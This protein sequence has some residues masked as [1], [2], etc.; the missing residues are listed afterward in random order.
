[1]TQLDVL[2]DESEPVSKRTRRA[3]VVASI[4]DPNLKDRT[5][6]APLF[7]SMKEKQEK[8]YRKEVE[9]L[10]QS[11]KTRLS[12]W[13]N[14][15]GIEKD[16]TRVCPV[17]H[18]AS[19]SSTSTNPL[20]PEKTISPTVALGGSLPHFD[21][22][23]TPDPYAS[24][25]PSIPYSLAH[26]PARVTPPSPSIW[27][28]ILDTDP[29]LIVELTDTPVKPCI[30][31]PQFRSIDRPMQEAC[32]SV[33]SSLVRPAPGLVT[34]WTPT[35]S[36]DWRSTR[37]EPRKPHDLT[38]F[39]SKWKDEDTA[40]RRN[41][42]APV[43][44]VTGSTG[45][46]KTSLVYAAAAEL[47]IQVLE[48]S[49]AD[50]SWESNGR[51]QLSEAVKEALQSRQVKQ[52]S[53]QSQIVLIDDVDVLIR[54][55]RSVIASLVGITDD[56]KRPLV[57]TCSDASCFDGSNLFLD[58][59]F[60]IP[61]M[62][63]DRVAFLAYAYDRALDWP[64]RDE[65]TY[66]A[67]ARDCSGD[68]RKLANLVEI[69]RVHRSHNHADDYFT[70]PSQI[71][72]YLENVEGLP[73]CLVNRD[74][75]KGVID[76][77]DVAQAEME[78]LNL[79]QVSRN[80]SDL[81]VADIIADDGVSARIAL[82]R[83]CTAAKGVS[84]P[85]KALQLHSHQSSITH[86]RLHAVM[87]PFLSTRFMG[88]IGT[89]QIGQTANALGQLAKYSTAA[90]FSSRRVRCLLDQTGRPDDAEAL[91]QLGNVYAYN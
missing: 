37:L 21:C 48:V 90:E 34:D 11:T 1:M 45:S 71:V 78:H 2:V 30:S 13:R 64:I 42:V 32:L 4:G 79:A 20:P 65:E 82:S 16:S 26:R 10:A 31:A 80:I 86:D 33:L 46:G 28:K 57:L 38:K 70:N 25:F 51:R 18:R 15:V 88:S 14:V 43:L 76:M 61:P 8:L 67:I 84:T 56:S 41:K 39:L 66:L 83:G 73:V 55:D 23:M 40:V 5:K 69:S 77:L 9:K 27:S 81:V 22:G 60:S 7:L 74:G 54:E 49:P 19:I 53:A 36:R 3:G 72:R 35:S 58:E 17:F 59:T 29:P 62:S 91:R 44:L 75:R 52:E 85:I 63:I 47:N 87:V 24:L 6:V 12:D 50:F 89:R 68:L